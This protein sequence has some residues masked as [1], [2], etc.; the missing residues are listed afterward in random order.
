[1]DSGT[2][3]AGAK[4]TEEDGMNCKGEIMTGGEVASVFAFSFALL[5]VGVL[6]FGQVP[7]A[8]AIETGWGFSAAQPILKLKI[9]WGG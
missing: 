3:Q 9:V 1:M 7:I 5:V 4:C 8:Q 2:T 6:V